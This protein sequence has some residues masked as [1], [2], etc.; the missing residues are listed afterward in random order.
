MLMKRA[1]KYKQNGKEEKIENRTK[2]N[3]GFCENVRTEFNIS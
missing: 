3:K 1:L 2:N